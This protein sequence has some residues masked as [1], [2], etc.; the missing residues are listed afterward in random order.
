[1]EGDD[2]EPGIGNRYAS[3][4]TPFRSGDLCCMG[5]RLFAI[6]AGLVAIAIAAWYLWPG[7]AAPPALPSLPTSRQEAKP[8]PKGPEHPVEAKADAALPALKESDP[9][10]LQG[11]AS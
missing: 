11:L 9:A 8:A 5:A 10:M 1:M 6:V 3:V 7:D 2:I 4:G